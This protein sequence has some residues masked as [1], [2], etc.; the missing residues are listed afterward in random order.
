[1]PRLCASRCEMLHKIQLTHRMTTEQEHPKPLT[2]HQNERMMAR[3]P[4]VV[5]V[6]AALVGVGIVSA[7][8]CAG[9]AVKFDTIL[10]IIQFVF[11]TA[12]VVVNGFV[13]YGVAL[14]EEDN[15]KEVKQKGWRILVKALIAEAAVGFLLLTVDTTVEVR[16]Q[17]EVSAAQTKAS[18]ADLE[19]GNLGVD[20]KNIHGF[21]TAQESQISSQFSQF[22]SFAT[23]EEAQTK[24][25]IDELDRDR[26]E[27]DKSRAA[28]Q[29]AAKQAQADIAAFQAA[30][31]PRFIAPDKQPE[32][33]AKMKAFTGLKV[34]VVLP[35]TT[36]ADAGPL[37]DQL[38]SLLTKAQWKVGTGGMLSGWAKF[39]LVCVGDHPEQKVNSAAI[40]LVLTLRADGIQ[41]FTD[42]QLGPFVP[43]SISNTT[44]PVIAK[45]DMTIIVGAKQ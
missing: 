38:G 42:P 14:E 31:R 40:A 33:I 9:T 20:V 17:H 15:P 36:T 22:T 13:W 45:P 43:V 10:L 16:Q 19:A 27:L 30:V 25:L 34:N 35:P 8:T 4:R 44:S 41:S 1:M 28:A 3:W 26:S 21:V 32:F 12:L 23:V 7:Y 39:V 29:A 37:A 6:L 11:G 2:D 5:G 18:S 24:R